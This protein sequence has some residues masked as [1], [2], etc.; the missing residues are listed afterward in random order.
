[1]TLDDEDHFG[2]TNEMVEPSKNPGELDVDPLVVANIAIDISQREVERLHHEIKRLKFNNL[3][4]SE[5]VCCEYEHTRVARMQREEMAVQLAAAEETNRNNDELEFRLATSE[6]LCDA[7]QSRLAA[8]EALL[9]EAAAAKS[10]EVLCT[11][12]WYQRA[13]KVCGD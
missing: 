11:P 5:Q 13:K 2:D 3:Q 9:R 8:A 4:L 6:S 12:G 10:C 7:L 1:M